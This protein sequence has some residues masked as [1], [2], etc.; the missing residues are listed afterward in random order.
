MEQRCWCLNPV[1]NRMD[2]IPTRTKAQIWTKT[3]RYFLSESR[4]CKVFG[5]NNNVPI[6]SVRAHLW[7]QNI[8][9]F[10]VIISRRTEFVLSIYK[11]Y[12]MCHFIEIV[13][14]SYA[15]YNVVICNTWIFTCTLVSIQIKSNV[16]ILEL[17]VSIVPIL[18][19]FHKQND[20]AIN[21][22]C[23]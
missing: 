6:V 3:L 9:W 13:S 16:E 20:N 12:R 18:R 22:T 17:T 1:F 4:K 14:S 7:F 15:L 11:L 8:A 19:V 10:P 2:H 23:K 21:V 5:K